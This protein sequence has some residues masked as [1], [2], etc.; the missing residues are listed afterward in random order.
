MF[1]LFIQKIVTCLNTSTLVASNSIFFILCRQDEW[2]SY[3]DSAAPSPGVSMSY[4][5]ILPLS[6][7]LSLSLTHTHT[8]KKTYANPAT[9]GSVQYDNPSTPSPFVPDSPQSG[10]SSHYGS[11]Y[12][13]RLHNSI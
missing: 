6:L 13:A 2:S 8:Y 5:H 9:P 7:S 12:N 3:Y 1:Y 10:S 4:V 11:H